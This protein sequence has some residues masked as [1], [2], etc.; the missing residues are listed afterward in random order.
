MTF[1]HDATFETSACRNLMDIHDY[2][3]NLLIRLRNERMS[4]EVGV[5]SCPFKGD[6]F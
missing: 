5:L 1:G 3:N 2:G 6:K 4:D